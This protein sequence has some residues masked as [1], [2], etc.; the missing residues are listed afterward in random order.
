[1]VETDPTVPSLESLAIGTDLE[2]IAVGIESIQRMLIGVGSIDV[3]TENFTDNE[4]ELTRIL[5]LENLSCADLGV[6]DTSVSLEAFGD[7]VRLVINALMRA[8]DKFVEFVRNCFEAVTNDV[9]QV[10]AFLQ[11]TKL[12]LSSKRGAFPKQAR[13]SLGR[14]TAFLA[15]DRGT[16]RGV[17]DLISGLNELRMQLGL[18]RQYYAE[19]IAKLGTVIPAM[20]SKV[21]LD[22]GTDT[23]V[24]LAVLEELN[25]TFSTISF[26]TIANRVTKITPF[27]DN[28]FPAGASYIGAPLMGMRSL[29]FVFGEKLHPE[30][31]RSD[32]PVARANAIQSSRIYL[33]RSNPNRRPPQ[34]DTTVEAMTYPSIVDFL[35]NI[36]ALVAEAAASYDTN[37][38]RHLRY[39][40]KEMQRA[41]GRLT[42]V[43][44]GNTNHLFP[45]VNY[46]STYIEWA[47]SP[48][49]QMLSLSLLVSRE[50]ILFA[51]K[52]IANL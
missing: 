22:P 42:A 6:D 43:K 24:N 15:T 45:F 52:H 12:R 44:T 4:N 21:H 25:R 27:T 8:L 10:G 46:C 19:P 3:T 32:N 20:L 49:L 33:T 48:Y 26:E 13:I 2:E 17:R 18:V 7:K 41:L 5:S 11:D 29:V 36:E 16:V 23:S 47:R 51:K 38:K 1:M 50:T 28:R 39:S 9:S 31:Y 37:L 14:Q 35:K 34:G 40:S 30:E